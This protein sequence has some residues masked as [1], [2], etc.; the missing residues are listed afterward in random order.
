VL[1]EG[2]DVEAGPVGQGGVPHDLLDPLPVGKRPAGR[3]VGLEVAERDHAE[4]HEVLPAQAVVMTSLPSVPP[5]NAA[6]AAGAWS[7]G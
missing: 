5:V 7:S 3:R 4:F 1:A 2:E 6:N